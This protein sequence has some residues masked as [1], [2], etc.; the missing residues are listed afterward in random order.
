MAPS[1]ANPSNFHRAPVAAKVRCLM[2]QRPDRCDRCIAND[3]DDCVFTLPKRSGTRNH[4]YPRRRRRTPTTTHQDQLSA[5][6]TSPSPSPSPS[7]NQAPDTTASAA[8]TPMLDSH[9]I[10]RSDQNSEQQPY[11]YDDHQ[12]RQ[13]Q[14][15]IT[16]E[17]RA[18]IVAT[19]ASLK[20]RRGAPFSFVTSGDKPEFSARA[21]PEEPSY[22]QQQQQQ[23]SSEQTQSISPP[24]SLK[25]SWLLRP[26]RP[27]TGSNSGDGGRTPLPIVK[28]PSYVSSMS[29]GQTTA[30][31]IECGILTHSASVALFRHFMLEM[32]AKWE[33]LLDP[34]RDT[35]DT[36][37][38][39]S[40][41]LF[42]TILF[43]SSKFANYAD[44]SLVSATDPF[45]QSRLCSLARN[46]AIRTFAEGDRS[47]ETMQA[48]YLLVCWK[49]P[50]DDVSYLHSGYAIR[51]LNDLDLE[52]GDGELSVRRKR[53]WLALFRQDKQQSLF[54]MRRASLSAGDEDAPFIG[55]LDTWLR[56]PYAT[57]LDFVACCSADVRR[58]QY[59]LRIM[60]Q[61]A[62]STMSPCL[63]DLMDSELN[64]WRSTWKNHLMGN[65]VRRE[66]G[67]SLLDDKQLRPGKRHL[68]SVLSLWEHSIK[69]N[70]SSSILRQALLA[71]VTSTLRPSDQPQA[72]ASV[73]L[74]LPAIEQVLSS[75]V[76]GLSSSIEGAFGTLQTLLAFA[77]EDLRRAPDAVL[78]L[79]PNA[80]LFLCLLLSLPPKGIL[81]PSFQ[82]TAIDL[83]QSVAQHVS[84][85]I[86]STQDTLNLHY[87]YLNSLVDLL[88]PA[89]P[90]QPPSNMP[91]MVGPSNFD[92]TESREEANDLQH[93]ETALEAAQVLAGGMTGLNYMVDDNDACFG[94]TSEP[95]Q[96]LHMQSLA[97]LL[98]TD[99]FWEAPPV[100]LDMNLHAQ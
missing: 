33:Y 52:Q 38:E 37:R 50:D 16:A 55:N 29:L 19:L 53:A 7:S 20:G 45:L 42:T 21:V 27:T 30:D 82:K 14:P 47:I 64:K 70:V 39:R 24:S 46:L 75:D 79:G 80:S 62:S 8:P 34:H 89:T 71:A 4:P 10:S 59:K 31:P 87:A 68:S 1:T 36:I 85:S 23:Q 18:R 17:I 100:A 51:I 22:Q 54:F 35:H 94:M 48:F 26:L 13:Q 91:N 72:Q 92:L 5:Q 25:L 81:G 99:F 32:N 15:P 86:Q 74:D 78:L 49:D 84:Q 61:K 69:L 88:S 83:I 43:C 9:G 40:K 28:M 44:G 95:P 12:Q 63:L 56:M 73:G 57:P 11:R 60:A 76:P 96:S 6:P 3:T 65:G 97:N 58:I 90:A 2:S 41:L 67:D 98:E 77:T 66:N 93:D